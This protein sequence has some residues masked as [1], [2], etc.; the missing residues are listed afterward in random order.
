LQRARAADASGN[1]E[2]CLKALEEASHDRWTTERS[3]ARLRDR[4]Q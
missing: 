1:R 3:P 2:D 4:S